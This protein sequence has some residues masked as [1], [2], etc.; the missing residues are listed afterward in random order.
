MK[1]QKLLKNSYNQ[2]QDNHV[3]LDDLKRLIKQNY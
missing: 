3:G 2:L 1:Y